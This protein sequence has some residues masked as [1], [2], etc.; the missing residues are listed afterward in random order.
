MVM[1]GQAEF[2]YILFSRVRFLFLIQFPPHIPHILGIQCPWCCRRWWNS[3]NR[4]ILNRCQWQSVLSCQFQNSPQDICH[5]TLTKSFQCPA[6]TGNVFDS[7]LVKCIE[8]CSPENP[9]CSWSSA[10]HRGHVPCSSRPRSGC[11]PENYW[12]KI[13]LDHWHWPRDCS[14]IRCNCHTF[15]NCDMTFATRTAP[16]LKTSM[17]SW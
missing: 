4:R 16:D 3:K 7:I 15:R 1:T 13:P 9:W 2:K 5:C 10:W 6:S 12:T 11:I 8:V 17:R 14:Q